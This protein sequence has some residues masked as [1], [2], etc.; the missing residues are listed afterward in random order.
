MSMIS[1]Q[2][3]DR[4]HV[5]DSNRTVIRYLLSRMKSYRAYRAHPK[6][7]RHALLREA[8]DRHAVNR[9]LYQRVMGGRF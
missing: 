9:K 5:A 7:E 3:V 4:C 8:I 1:N 2:I 6:K